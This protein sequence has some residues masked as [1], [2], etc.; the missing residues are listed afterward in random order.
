MNRLVSLLR[1]FLG[2]FAVGRAHA[3]SRTINFTRSPVLAGQSGTPLPNRLSG[4][5]GTAFDEL[6]EKKS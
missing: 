5:L 1:A 4:N 6:T 2:V 3:Q